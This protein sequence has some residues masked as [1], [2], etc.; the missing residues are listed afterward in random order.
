[1]PC[2][3]DKVDPQGRV[4]VDI[5]KQ[6]PHGL[7]ED[8]IVYAFEAGSATATESAEGKQYLGEFRVTV[9]Q[10]AGVTLEPV[11]LIDNRAGERLAASEG[12]WSLYETMPIDRHRLFAGYSE[13]ALRAMLPAESVEEYLRHG[14]E[15]TRDDDQW[16][17]TGLDEDGKRVGPDN[18]DQAVKRLYDRS[19]RDYAYIFNELAGNKVVTLARQEAVTKDND[20]LVKALAGAEETGQVP[21]ATNRYRRQRFD[22]YET[23][24]SRHRIAS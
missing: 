2:P 17:V 21:P 1:M 23:R 4:S 20:R 22:R 19:L 3:P 9:V 11:L 14:T 15:A 12:P 5:T 7:E 8:A 6:L 16:H 24:P 10:A 13:E 18:I